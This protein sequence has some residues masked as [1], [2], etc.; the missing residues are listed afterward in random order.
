[1]LDQ[2]FLEALRSAYWPLYVTAIT[3]GLFRFAYSNRWCIGRTTFA[4]LFGSLVQTVWAG[5]GFLAWW[6]HLAIDA[7]IF[8]VVTMPPRHYWQS[9]MGA[10]LLAQ[11]AMHC[12]WA[13]APDLARVH[14]FVCITLGFAKC[15]VLLLWSGGPRV[16]HYLSRTAGVVTRVV[17]APAH[18]K[19]AR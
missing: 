8:F 16:E 2:D 9:T 13:L 12:I 10:L 7:A 18:G 11:I 6:Q 15:A 1:V 17:L 4:L 14:W 3:A 5:S 19:L